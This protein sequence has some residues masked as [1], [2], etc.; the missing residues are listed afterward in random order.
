VHAGR[1]HVHQ[2]DARQH[3]LIPDVP[4]GG[5]RNRYERRWHLHRMQYLDGK[6]VVLPRLTRTMGFSQAAGYTV[7]M[8][9]EHPPLPTDDSPK[10][11][12]LTTKIWYE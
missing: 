10:T 3:G 11:P 12:P 5:C 7:G 9:G 4:E 1:L 8:F 6:C 2:H